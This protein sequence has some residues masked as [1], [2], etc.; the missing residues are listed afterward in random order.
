[1]FDLELHS[2]FDF[3]SKDFLDV[4]LR[5]DATPFQHPVWLDRLYARVVPRVGAEPAVVT[6]RS[7]RDGRLVVVLPLVRRRSAGI[8]VIEFADLAVTDYVAPICRRDMLP[9]LLSDR[10][11]GCR[12]LAALQPYDL[13]RICKV[14]HEWAS[15]TGALLP[16]SQAKS[17]TGA[18][19]VSLFSPFD[20]WRASMLE[21]GFA[22]FLDK[23]RKLLGKKG[24]LRLETADDV[25]SIETAFSAMQRFRRFRFKADEDLLQRAE[26]FEFYKDVAVSGAQSGLCR[27]YVLYLENRLIAT[28][29]GLSHRGAYR[30]YV[31][32]R[33]RNYRFNYPAW[34]AFWSLIWRDGF[35]AGLEHRSTFVR[36]EDVHATPRQTMNRVA[37]WLG[38]SKRHS[39]LESTFNG[40]PWVVESGGRTWTG[41]RPEQARRHSRNMSW[42][43]RAIVFAL[44]Q[45]NFDAWDY[46]YPK[47]FALR[48]VRSLC[49]VLVLVVPMRLEFASDAA[50]TTTLLRPALRNARFGI[51]GRTI[52][53]LLLARIALRVLIFAELCRR[54]AVSKRL[55]RPI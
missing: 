23:K 7:R 43:D 34:K 52:W 42:V 44:F 13:L 38:L 29:F 49:L 28:M 10:S 51:A 1:M 25:V 46:P 11:I 3:Q 37:E 32:H 18:Y 47:R 54:I 16:G 31:E 26:Y 17:N 4:F 55:A 22:R 8:K 12:I 20:T 40:K 35:H 6:L 21:P 48:W 30:A 39:L 41:T 24:H 45:E 2:D 36:F 14:R 19:T 27:I 9:A 50:M 5:S 15:L 53:R 33:R